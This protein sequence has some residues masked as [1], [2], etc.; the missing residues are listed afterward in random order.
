MGWSSKS[1]KFVRDAF[2][3]YYRRLSTL[4][5]PTYI[6]SREFGFLTFD[7][8]SMLRH[9]SFKSANELEIF[10]EKTVPSDAYFSGA[11]YEQ[12]AAEMDRKEWLGADLIF[13]VDADHIPTSCNK[14]HDEWICGTCDFI[15]RGLTPEKCPVCGGQKFEVKTWP[16]ETCLDSAKEE[17]LKLL[18]IL[19]HD[20]GFPEKE[21]HVLFSGH[22]GYHVHIYD[23]TAKNADAMAR[24]EIVDYI[25]GLGFDIA[26]HGF[27]DRE[28]KTRGTLKRSNLNNSGWHGR[29]I[30]RVHDLISNAK[31]DEYEGLGLRSDIGSALIKNKERI[32]KD[33]KSTGHWGVTKGVGFETWKKI[34]EFCVYSQSAKID[35]VVTTDIHR[36]I[37]LTDSLHGKT[38]LKK[39]EFPISTIEDFDPFKSAIAFKDGTVVVFVSDSPLFRIGDE[40][41][42]PYK[43]QKVELPTAAAMLLICK[44]RAEVLD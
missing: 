44:G 16:C 1:R 35:T 37:R 34:I 20:F 14:V 21:M 32:L 33:L 19:T 41:F 39:V 5:A 12:P 17:T 15:G 8:R 25:C 30:K 24:K 26:S 40:T 28:W 23:E 43:A 6:E 27:G 18:D 22:R 38:G 7:N 10:L 11:Y 29:V 4:K 3:E 42:G 2:A 31:Q 9:I 13:D 36:L